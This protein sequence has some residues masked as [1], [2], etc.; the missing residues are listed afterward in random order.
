VA[1]AFGGVAIAIVLT[2][3]GLGFAKLGGGIALLVIG[4]TSGGAIGGLGFAELGGGIALVIGGT[5]SDGAIGGLAEAKL[6]IA[7]ATWFAILIGLANFGVA[8]IISA[9]K[10]SLAG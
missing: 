5:A 7:G 6:L 4:A 3:C 10:F 1:G 8:E 9:F 2:A